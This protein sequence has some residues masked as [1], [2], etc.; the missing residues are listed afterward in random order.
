MWRLDSSSTMA[1]GSVPR[2]APAGARA[3]GGSIGRDRGSPAGRQPT[4]GVAAARRA[5]VCSPTNR[6]CRQGRRSRR[7]AGSRATTRSRREPARSAGGRRVLARGRPA[8]A[9]GTGRAPS[10]RRRHRAGR[11]SLRHPARGRSSVR[12]VRRQPGAG[13]RAISPRPARSPAAGGP[14]RARPAALAPLAGASRHSCAGKR[15]RRSP[16]RSGGSIHVEVER[17]S[18]STG[19]VD[20]LSPK[21]RGGAERRRALW[22]AGCARRPRCIP[23]AGA[24]TTKKDARQDAD[25]TRDLDVALSGE[26]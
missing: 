1:H 20:A 16:L 7:R 10:A 26:Q 3:G 15:A 2:A 12:S 4:R 17:P 22:P 6:G 11:C 25:R 8:R 14:E 13:A 21:C 23:R 18:G 24:P 9:C 19:P 5:W